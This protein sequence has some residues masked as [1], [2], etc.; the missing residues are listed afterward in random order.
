MAQVVEAE[1]GAS[2][3]V[4]G[5]VEAVAGMHLLPGPRVEPGRVPM[6]LPDGEWLAVGAGEHQG[7]RVG[8]GVGREV[9]ADVLGQVRGE[10]DGPASGV[11][12]RGGDDALAADGDGGAVDGLQ[13]RVG[14][15]PHG[16]GVRQGVVPAV[17]VGVR[18]GRQRL[19]VQRCEPAFVEVEVVLAGAVLE[20]TSLDQPLVDPLAGELVEGDLLHLQL[21]AP[22]LRW[23]PLV[24]FDELAFVRE[25][26]LGPL[27]GGEGDA[28]P[29]QLAV[30]AGVADL[31]SSPGL[32][33][34]A[35]APVLLLG[36]FAPWSEPPRK[37]PAGNAWGTFDAPNG[38]LRLLRHRTRGAAFPHHNT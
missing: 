38:P 19:V 4:P 5:T 14:V 15:D 16:G 22:S 26:A 3:L 30:G 13:Q 36:L 9:L 28:G 1:V 2:D 20:Q 8:A 10:V 11:R 37:F 6:D 7:V 18:E 32:Y 27:A 34:G 35:E 33:D 17:D 12:L 23:R 25:P 21:G 29:V 24:E 31:E